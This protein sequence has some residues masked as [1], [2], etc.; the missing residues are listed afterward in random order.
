MKVYTNFEQIDQDLRILKL[1]KEIKEEEL[2]LNIN[3]AKSGLSLGF[4]PVTTISSMIG[5]ILQKAAVAKLVSLIFG[6]KRVKEMDT[7]KEHKV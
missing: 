7:G 6:Y 5:S 1:K 4:S 3:G 2:K